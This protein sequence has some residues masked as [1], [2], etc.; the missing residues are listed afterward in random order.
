LKELDRLEAMFVRAAHGSGH[1]T[2][3]SL[4]ASIGS[5]ALLVMVLK[6]IFD[7]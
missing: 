3:F 4:A 6:M 7:N 1:A 2:V 5:A